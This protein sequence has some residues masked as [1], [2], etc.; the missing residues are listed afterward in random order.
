MVFLLLSFCNLW[1]YKCIF[2][3][4]LL[5]LCLKVE[6]YRRHRPCQGSGQKL[7]WRRLYEMLVN[8]VDYRK[9]T[10]SAMLVAAFVARMICVKSGLGHK[11]LYILRATPLVSALIL[12]SVYVTSALFCTVSCRWNVHNNSACRTAQASLTV[13]SNWSDCGSG[14]LAGGFTII[15]SSL[16]VVWTTYRSLCQLKWICSLQLHITA[17]MRHVFRGSALWMF[18]LAV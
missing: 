3:G 6:L 2:N 13:A 12:P 15:M 7:V 4:L 9:L 16:L 1:K 17:F 18:F 11:C 14:R 5:C 8:T 10:F